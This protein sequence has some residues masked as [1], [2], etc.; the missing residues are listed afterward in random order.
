MWLAPRIDGP[1]D[2]SI[3]AATK[4]QNIWHGPVRS[5]KTVASLLAWVEYVDQAPPGDLVM[6]GKT[7]TT[8]QRNILQPLQQFLG[9]NFGY[10]MGRHEAW[11]RSVTQDRWRSIWLAGANDERSEGK[12]RGMTA[13]GAY[14]DELTLWPEGFYKQMLARLSVRGAR[15][16]GT[17]N[18]DG[19]Y[20]WLKANYL[21]RADV[22]NLAGFSWS[23]DDNEHLDADYV[24][25]LKREYG[26][27]T[28]WYKR[29]IDGLWVAAEG[30]VYDFFNE[31]EHV[32][33][34][35]PSEPDELFLSVDY[36][37]SNAT[38]AGL[39]GAWREPVNGLKA[40]RLRGYYHSGRD[41][42]RQKTD[43]EYADDLDREFEDVKPRIKRVILD[44]SAASFKAELRKRGWKVLEANN[45]VLDGIRT[46]AK[47]LKSGEYAI[48]DH[49]TNKQAIRDYGAY[50]WDS[51]AQA[52]GEDKPLKQH[53]HTKDEERYALH[54]LF[55]ARVGTDVKTARTIYR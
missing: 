2:R 3:L 31:S 32:I 46:Q 34:A 26:E 33:K 47:M 15:L 30:A 27:G 8:L 12:V 44:P 53:D 48:I 43:S 24:A 20:H 16:F 5:G 50:L 49:P 42:G 17:T 29:F 40:A 9:S 52:R 23:I 6:I 14:G 22:L 38:S 54:T 36:G 21:D 13:A 39:Y 4:R 45:D 35:V 37:T 25:D 51:K 10:S 28:L 18:P 19:P 1:A 41:T 11:L 7:E 55:A